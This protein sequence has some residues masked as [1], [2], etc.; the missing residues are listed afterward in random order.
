MGASRTNSSFWVADAEL[1][2]SCPCKSAWP[3]V[4]KEASLLWHALP[5]KRGAEA[6]DKD[7]EAKVEE[8]KAPPGSEGRCLLVPAS[9]FGRCPL[10]RFETILQLNVKREM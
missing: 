8:E 6:G 10:I 7:E 3:F 4:S 1:S 9:F 5:S 2:R